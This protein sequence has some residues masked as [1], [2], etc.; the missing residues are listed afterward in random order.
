[1][2]GYAHANTTV[3]ATVV[4]G[5]KTKGIF[6]Q[7][8]EVLA[9]SLSGLSTD[10]PLVY[11]PTTYN[12]SHVNPAGPTLWAAVFGLN[13]NGNIICISVTDGFTSVACR[14]NNTCVSIKCPENGVVH[15]S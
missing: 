13:R 3:I 4:L 10:I 12:I 2:G 8:C 15:A 9:I 11:V 14:R 7:K 6:T 1:M 5:N